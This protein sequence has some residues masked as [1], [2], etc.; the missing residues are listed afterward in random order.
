MKTTV[1]DLLRESDTF[2]KSEM[3]KTYIDC[4]FVLISSPEEIV[5]VF[6][7][8]KDFEYHANLVAYYCQKAK[9]PSSWEH[10]PDVY[11]IYSSPYSINGGGWFRF[12]FAKSELMIR[13]IS[14]AY[15]RFHKDKLEKV[16]QS[17]DFV[18]GMN[19]LYSE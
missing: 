4:K 1:V 16:L 8:L 14:T 5:L 12:D 2:K 13:G 6:G 3:L 18:D 15:G 11:L 7:P 10:K 19:I 17:A 9:I